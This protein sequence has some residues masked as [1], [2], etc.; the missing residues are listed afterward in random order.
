MKLDRCVRLV[1]CLGKEIGPA[2]RYCVPPH[3]S[4]GCRG[5]RLVHQPLIWFPSFGFIRRGWRRLKALA[6]HLSPLAP[7]ELG[8]GMP[9]MGILL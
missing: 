8:F 7:G 3:A 9:D 6:L 1:L 2:R 4:E 5:R